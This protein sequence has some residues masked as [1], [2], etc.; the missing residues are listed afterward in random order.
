MSPAPRVVK[1]AAV[2]AVPVALAVLVVLAALAVL[3]ALAAPVVMA[4]L[5]RLRRSTEARMSLARSPCGTRAELACGRPPGARFQGVF[6]FGPG[7][8]TTRLAT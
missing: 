8:C 1:V 3:V 2:A 6:A 5:L 4:A 7:T